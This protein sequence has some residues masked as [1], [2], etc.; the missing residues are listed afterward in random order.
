MGDRYGRN[1]RVRSRSNDRKSHRNRSRDRR[2]SRSRDSPPKRRLEE[3]TKP[4]DTYTLYNIILKGK[5]SNPSGQYERTTEQRLRRR[6][7]RG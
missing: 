4:L 5:K 6:L 1:F 7:S 2:R 3:P